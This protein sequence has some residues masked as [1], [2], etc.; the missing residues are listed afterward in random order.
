MAPRS[1]A[2]DNCYSI[3]KSGCA[4]SVHGNTCAYCRRNGLT[5]TWH[6]R[7]AQPDVK[8]PRSATQRFLGGQQQTVMADLRVGPAQPTS[9]STLGTQSAGYANFTSSSSAADGTAGYSYPYVATAGPYYGSAN[10]QQHTQPT[11][12][13][14]HVFSGAQRR[15]ALP[16]RPRGPF[17][18]QCWASRGEERRPAYQAEPPDG[19]FLCQECHIG[20]LYA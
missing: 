13:A 8:D 6:H 4:K 11:Q 9:S 5:C 18:S 10:L 1:T 15:R 19:P 14:I 17:C 16:S 3:K 12:P 7:D 2:C 20:D